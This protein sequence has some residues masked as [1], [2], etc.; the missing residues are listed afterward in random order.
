MRAWR[1]QDRMTSLKEI[2]GR[3]VEPEEVKAALVAGMA[4]TLG[5]EF[6]SG[7]LGSEERALACDFASE[8]IFNY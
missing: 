5:I 7:K 1:L 3:H 6:Q 4:G 8:G 2:L